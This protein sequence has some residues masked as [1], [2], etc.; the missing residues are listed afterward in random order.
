[1]DFRRF[2]LAALLVFMPFIAAACGEPAD[3]G[4]E[5][6][7]PEFCGWAIEIQANQPTPPPPVD[8][9]LPLDVDRL[10][11][12]S[13]DLSNFAGT[14]ESAAAFAPADT[15][16]DFT[17]LASFHR[18]VAFII[19]GSDSLR[20]EAIDMAND[21]VDTVIDTLDDECGVTI[22]RAAALAFVDA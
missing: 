14:L 18:E 20:P 10:V 6:A 22:D 16:S 1:M 3:E 5:G 12:I 21:A 9:E 4:P 15:Q 8:P 2:A 19:T 17:Q 7:K 11:A 13:D